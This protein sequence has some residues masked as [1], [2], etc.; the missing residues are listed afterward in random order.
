LKLRLSD[1]LGLLVRFQ[2]GLLDR[3]DR[4][5]RLTLLGLLCLSDQLGQSRLWALWGL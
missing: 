5:R 3:W 1:P 2:M 4:L